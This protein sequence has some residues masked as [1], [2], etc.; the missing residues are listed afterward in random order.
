MSIRVPF[1][2]FA[3]PALQEPA[4]KLEMVQWFHGDF[5]V[6][7]FY[8]SAFLI[9]KWNEVDKS[10]ASGWLSIEHIA[11]KYCDVV[12]AIAQCHGHWAIAH[13]IRSRLQDHPDHSVRRNGGRVII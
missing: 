1:K 4:G 2:V 6:Q 11:V 9:K 3:M 8:S 5:T 12:H 13:S 7:K 10:Q